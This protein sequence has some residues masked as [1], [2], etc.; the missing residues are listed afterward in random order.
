M[1]AKKICKFKLERRSAISRQ[2]R[3]QRH[4]EIILPRQEFVIFNQSRKTSPQRMIWQGACL[5]TGAQ[6]TSIRLR[7]AK[8]YCRYTGTNFRLFS[9]NNRYCFSNDR[10]TSLGSLIITIPLSEAHTTKERVDVVSTDVS[11]L[12]GLDLLDKYGMFVNTITNRLNCPHRQLSISRIRKNGYVYLEWPKRDH[13]FFSSPELL[14]LHRGFSHPATDKLY[15]V[16]RMARPYETNPDT[17][18]VLDQ[19]KQAC[20]T[21]QRLGPTLIRLKTSLPTE[22]SAKFGEELSMDLMFLDGKA[23]LHIFDSATRFSSA[24]FLDKDFDQSV[25][26]IWL[27]FIQVWC[28]MYT[29]YPNRIRVEQGSSFTSDRWRQF[30]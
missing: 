21:Y 8:A 19:I 2:V 18:Q 12:I 11:L 30:C 9:N 27:A 10:Q 15:N 20:D 28:T 5:D 4:R 7:Q 6:R 1:R 24:A 26:G 3:S 14:R 23:L 17:K 25:E 16:L 29:G 13:I 22:D